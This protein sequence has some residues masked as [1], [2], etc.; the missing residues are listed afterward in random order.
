MYHLYTYYVCTCKLPG[1]V[2]TAIWWFC[3]FIRCLFLFA[4]C[5]PA[6]CT[7]K[8]IIHPLQLPAACVT[9]FETKNKNTH[10]LE[11]KGFPRGGRWQASAP[12]FCSPGVSIAKKTTK[13]SDYMALVLYVGLQCHMLQ[14]SL[15]PAVNMLMILSFIQ[16]C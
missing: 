2:L 10:I 8:L 9:Y 15:K 3:P 14:E 6:S 7:F 4:G 1:L 12:L 11:D 16:S 13:I 5:V